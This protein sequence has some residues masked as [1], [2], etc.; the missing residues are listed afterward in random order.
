[1]SID[2]TSLMTQIANPSTLCRPSGKIVCSVFY[3]I[4]AHFSFPDAL[5][6]EHLPRITRILHTPEKIAETSPVSLTAK[7]RFI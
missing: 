7:G 4:M 1:M 6:L 5:M 3:Y 2:S